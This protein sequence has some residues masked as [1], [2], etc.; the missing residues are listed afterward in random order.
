M[1]SITVPAR[2]AATRTAATRSRSVRSVTVRPRPRP[3]TRGGV[4]LTQ[5]GRV[6]A[7]TA[8]VVALLAIVMAAGQVADAADAGTAGQVA[9]SVVVVQ[10]GDTLW[11]IAQE[12][13][14]GHDPRAV[15][16]QVRELN[17]LGTRSIVPGQ[18]LVLPTLG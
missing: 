1:A 11:G 4:R 7:F 8:A 2:T 16:A 6:S 15:V 14:P 10:A 12:V 17:D 5:R 3:S 9:P 18:A 13:A